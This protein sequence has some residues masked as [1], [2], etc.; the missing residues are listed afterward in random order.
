MCA[1]AFAV[2]LNM[3]RKAIRYGNSG[4]FRVRSVGRDTVCAS[5]GHW[6]MGKM[7]GKINVDRLMGQFIIFGQNFFSAFLAPFV[8]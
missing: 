8:H 2:T 1:F 7:L 5:P 4:D 6:Q 3:L